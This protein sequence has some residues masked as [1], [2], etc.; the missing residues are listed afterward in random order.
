MPAATCRFLLASLIIAL[1]AGMVFTPG[2]PGEFLFDDVPNIT[3]NQA[4]H[5]TQLSAEALANVLTSLQLS[6]TTRSLPTLSFALDYWRAG[7]PDPMTFKITNIVLH[8]LTACVLAWF[9]RSLL[10]VAGVSVT[11]VRWPAL[12][13]ALAWA[14]HPLQ[15]SAVLYVVQ[16][17]QTMGTL[18]LILALWAYLLARQAQIEGRSGRT[19]LL[20]TLL[21]WIVAMG[22]KE[23]SALLPAY[24]LALELTLLRFAAADT[25]LADRL[26][27]GYLLA[28]LFA[29]AAY[30][31]V[32]IPHFWQGQAY[33]GRDYTAGERLLTQGRVL[34]MY[35]W[36]ILIPLPGH[37][38]F[39]YDWLQPSRSLLHPWTT[40]PA[41][42]LVLALLG[43]AWR[44]RVRWPLFALGVLLFFSAHII[45][46]NV[47]GLEL[48]FEHRNHFAL[49]GAVLAVG[50]LLGHIGSRLQ[51]R[52]A[53][54]AIGCAALIVALASATLMRAHTW[55]STLSI[56][57]I[58]TEHAPGSGRAWTQLCASYF[59]AGG[60]AVQNNPRLDEA[61]E[62]CI[63]GSAAVPQSL[64]SPT[65]LVV[66][67]SLR[68]DATPQDWNHLQQRLET[69]PMTRDNAR[70]FMI[71][72]FHARKGVKLD[73]QELLETFEV[74]AR[75]GA[76]GAF[77]TA[78][79][80][81]FVMNDLS[82][83]E[84]ALPYF[85]EAIEANP[86]NDP[87]PQQLG[88][89]LRAKGRPDLAEK[90]ERLG[91]ARSRIGDASSTGINAGPR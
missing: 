88:A 27:R 50:S 64:N 9:F 80:G 40:L 33:W 71:L 53:V 85:F 78:S 11:R 82:E 12:A 42:A 67:K 59:S 73:K 57:R 43:I 36:Q 70:I 48:A 34:C 29:V 32:I 4:V 8:A 75:R 49:V 16:R 6:G 38:P 1:L 79:I 54:Q 37:M 14:A 15:V 44:L 23:D 21:L 18:F 24:T 41:I 30:V 81:Y 22:C 2:L 61:I 10:L 26:R 20:L 17:L 65:L 56:A 60:G 68:G 3:A 83:P 55:N 25:R 69:A 89:E 72:T 31:L 76:L 63:A 91:F 74:L 84:L 47:I 62:S 39:Y 90:V 45:T 66:L 77:N 7:G 46:S 19:G 28:T 86:P 52:S 58:A 13:L 51:I 87:F 35:L 5:L